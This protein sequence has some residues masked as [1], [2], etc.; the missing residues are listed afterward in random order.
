LCVFW[1]LRSPQHACLDK[2]DRKREVESFKDRSINVLQCTAVC[3]SECCS[4]RS[5]LPMKIKDS[6]TGAG[7]RVSQIDRDRQRQTKTDKDRER[8]RERDFKKMRD[9]DKKDLVKKYV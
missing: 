4:E 9:K 3:C 6:N 7:K 8:Q 1:F 2:I 5:S